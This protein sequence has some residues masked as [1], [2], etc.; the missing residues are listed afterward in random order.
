MRSS[1]VTRFLAMSQLQLAQPNRVLHDKSLTTTAV[2]K[3][4]TK[5]N[6]NAAY[7]AYPTLASMYR[8]SVDP[9]YWED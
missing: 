4:S 7:Q 5:V 3:P 2:I 9:M 6:P 8:G 1:V